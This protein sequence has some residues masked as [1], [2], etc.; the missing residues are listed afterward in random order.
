ML[1]LVISL[2]LSFLL[3]LCPSANAQTNIHP[4]GPVKMPCEF[5][6][7]K[8]VRLNKIIWVCAT[9]NQ[10]VSETP[11]I[12]K[13]KYRGYQYV[14]TDFDVINFPP[15]LFENK[16]GELFVNG[17]NLKEHLSAIV[18]RDGTVSVD[19]FLSHDFE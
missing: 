17:L 3:F 19:Q 10:V 7:F 5:V 16:N 9:K 4:K 1:N 2:S 14:V 11:G 8:F 13:S 6:G 12:E 15:A 18:E